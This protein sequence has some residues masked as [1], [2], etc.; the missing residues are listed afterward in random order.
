MSKEIVGFFSASVLYAQFKNIKNT[1][2]FSETTIYT[3]QS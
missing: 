2:N 1:E 3:Q